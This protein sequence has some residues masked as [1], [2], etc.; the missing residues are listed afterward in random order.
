MIRPGAKQKL[1]MVVAFCLSL[2]CHAGEIAP[3]LKTNPFIKLANIEERLDN[4]A[5]AEHTTSVLFELRGTM[6]AGQQSLA[7][8]GGVIL[9]LGEEINGYK[10]VAVQQRQVVL[11]KNGNRK[12]LSVDDEKESNHR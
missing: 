1:T 7:N 12:I 2:V 6:V 5:P 10:L 9:S 4:T 3:A 11:L 8:I